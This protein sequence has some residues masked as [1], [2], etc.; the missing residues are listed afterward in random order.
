MGNPRNRSEEQDNVINTVTNLYESRQ[1]SCS[2]V[3]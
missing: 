3:Q 2:N 1:K